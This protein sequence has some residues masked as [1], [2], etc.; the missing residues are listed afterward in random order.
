LQLR[1]VTRLLGRYEGQ[2]LYG[3]WLINELLAAQQEYRLISL[4]AMAGAAFSDP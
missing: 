4:K 3:S 1:S 2:I